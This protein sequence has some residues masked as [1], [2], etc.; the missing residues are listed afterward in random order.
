MLVAD[1]QCE[2]HAKATISG[3]QLINIHILN[4]LIDSN[5]SF[6]QQLKLVQELFMGAGK[7]V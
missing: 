1:N 3:S 6:N 5:L 2:G 4:D 7:G